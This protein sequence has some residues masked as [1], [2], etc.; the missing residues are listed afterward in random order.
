MFGKSDLTLFDIWNLTSWNCCLTCTD[1]FCPSTFPPMGTCLSAP[2]HG[3]K[4]RIA[5]GFWSFLHIEIWTRAFCGLWGLWGFVFGFWG[6]DLDRCSFKSVMFARV[7]LLLFD[8]SHS[9]VFILRWENDISVCRHACSFHINTFMASC[10]S[11]TVMCVHARQ[12][13]T[14]AD[15]SL[16]HLDICGTLYYCANSTVASVDSLQVCFGIFPALSSCFASP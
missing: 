5:R 9:C 14:A 4:S 12:K 2:L 16:N 15:K 7:C 6:S 13:H 1:F 11:S 8:R 3:V 10:N